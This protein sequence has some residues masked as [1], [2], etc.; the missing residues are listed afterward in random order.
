MKI[1]IEDSKT[2]EQV[3][4]EFHQAYSHLK[5]QFFKKPHGVGE[6]SPKEDLLEPSKTIGEIRTTHN[7]GT[8]TFDNNTKVAE[9]ENAF[10]E[11]YGI[12]AQ[13]FRKSG[14]IWLETSKTDD[15][16]LE[17]QNETGKESDT[18]YNINTHNYARKD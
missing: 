4:E 18:Q 3:Q 8:I 10:Q 9:L 6:G 5:I 2:L 11:N 7:E 15:W 1:Q 13:V 12:S 17:K 14:A 16:T